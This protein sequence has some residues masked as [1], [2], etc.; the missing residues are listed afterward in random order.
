MAS[1]YIIAGPPGIGKSWNGHYFVNPQVGI[2]NHDY[3]ALRYKNAGVED[4]Q[5][6][7][8]QKAKEFVTSKLTN[9]LN[10]GLELNLGFDNHYSVIHDIRQR[11]PFRTITVILFYTDDLLLCLDRARVRQLAGGHDVE[12]SIIEAMYHNIFPLLAKYKYLI[13]RLQLVNVRAK[14]VEL[15]YSH[16]FS[17]PEPEFIAE[18]L[19]V[20]FRYYH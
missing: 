14:T 15:I 1:T 4:F 6:I 16:R 9:K 11:D 10:F 12:P 17:S 20:W 7:A 19:P 3:I 13:D 8:S 18:K 2:L 5:R